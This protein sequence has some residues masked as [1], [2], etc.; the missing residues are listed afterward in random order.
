[1]DLEDKVGQLLMAGLPRPEVDEFARH[2][3]VDLRAGGVVL[4]AQNAKSPTQVRAFTAELQ[5]LAQARD[6]P[7]PLFVSINHEGGAIVH[8]QGGVTVFPAPMALGA[9][10]SPDLA[11]AAG[12]HSAEELAAMG[13]NMN[14]APV[15]DVNSEPAN[16]VIGLRSF[17][18]DP[19]TVGRLGAEFARGAQAAGVIAVGKHFPGHGAVAV[20]SHYALPVVD[21]S[22]EEL[23]AEGLAPFRQAIGAGIEAIMSAHLAVP[24]LTGRADLPATLSPAVMSDLLR[25]SLG[26]RGLIITDDLDMQGVAGQVEAGE[27]A[28]RAVEAGADVVLF[29]RPASQD[30]AFHALLQAVQSGRLPEE[31]IDAS[32]RRILALKEEYALA[33]GAVGEL[34]TAGSPEHQALARQMAAAAVTGLQRDGLPLVAGRRTLVLTPQG[35]PAGEGGWT[36]L[37]EEV[38][39][40]APECQE[41]VYAPHDPA[42][43][44]LALAEMQAALG[45]F[46]QVIVG[47]WDAALQVRNLG[48][49]TPLRLLEALQA[50]GK[51]VAVLALQRPYDLARVPPGMAALATY[52]ATPEQVQAAVAA[53][54]GEAEATGTLPVPLQQAERNT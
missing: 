21:S 37:G 29:T 53:L 23:W 19:A 13:I 4:V 47:L 3:V 16:P 40:R 43:Q 35:V 2:A 48:D 39:R 24:A 12:L 45:E 17:G 54:F 33:G 46:D 44:A 18:A 52:G 49:D 1:M 11:Y 6:V 7:V 9:A 34:A 15:L 31:R 10:A 14:L 25:G 51:P 30:A 26:F 27:A 20:D 32:L 28:V 22:G 5:S 41:I 8:I 42:G 38:C 50:S 36:L